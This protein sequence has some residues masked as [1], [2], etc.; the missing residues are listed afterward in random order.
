M[1]EGHLTDKWKDQAAASKPKVPDLDGS[2][3]AANQN[4]ESAIKETKFYGVDLKVPYIP[5]LKL[6]QKSGEM[7]FVPY[8]LQPFVRYVPE[9]TV[10][11]IIVTTM[12]F[13]VTIAG[14]SLMPLAEW[15]GVYKVRWIKESVSGID[16]ENDPLFVE[17]IQI[18]P[19]KD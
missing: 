12:Q 15:L 13:E 11:K 2:Y 8:G 4:D 17:S 19:L 6:V 10:G 5:S 16:D 9:E 14:R 18:V 1:K 7:F 3:S